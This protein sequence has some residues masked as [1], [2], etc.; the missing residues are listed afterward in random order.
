MSA[1]EFLNYVP[2]YYDVE[3]VRLMRDVSKLV[4]RHVCTV[5]HPEFGRYPW[6]EQ[7]GIYSDLLD[8]MLDDALRLL[9]SLL[10]E[11]EDVG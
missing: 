7:N 9:E 8:D 5:D 11:V 2:R 6:L 1:D 3:Q 4:A 10:L